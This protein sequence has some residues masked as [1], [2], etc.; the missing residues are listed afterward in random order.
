MAATASMVGKSVSITVTRWSVEGDACFF[1]RVGFAGVSVSGLLEAGGSTSAGEDVDI[2]VGVDGIPPHTASRLRRGARAGGV[3][4]A[5][6]TTRAVF[7]V[8]HGEEA[9]G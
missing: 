4:C 8:L 3:R 6:V 9:V 1:L 2:V 7:R 5:V